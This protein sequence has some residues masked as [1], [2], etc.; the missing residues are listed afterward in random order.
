MY[1]CPTCNKE[2][3]TEELITKHYLKCW[4]EKYPTHQSKSAPRS[5]DINTRKINNDILNFFNSFQQE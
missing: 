2:F 5:E 3:D 1:I 4:K